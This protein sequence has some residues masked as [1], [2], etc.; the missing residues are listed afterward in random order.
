M[1]ALS[2]RCRGLFLVLATLVAGVS[3]ED[4]LSHNLSVG[5]GNDLAWLKAEGLSSG[6]GGNNS[7]EGSD[8]YNYFSLK[9][10]TPV[11]SLTNWGGVC[12]ERGWI[13]ENG[14]FFG[15]DVGGGGGSVNTDL[16]V[17]GSANADILGIASDTS[18]SVVEVGGGL[19]LG[20]ALS[21]SVDDLR[22]IPGAWIGYWYSGYS[23][24]IYNDA[25]VYADANVSVHDF[26]GPFVKV[27]WRFIE[28]MYRWLIGYYEVN[29]H[30]SVYT[31]GDRWNAGSQIDIDNSVSGFDRNHHQLTVGL[32]FGG[33][34]D[35]GGYS[36]NRR[37]GTMALNIVLPGLGSMVLQKDYLWG[38]IALGVGL[39]GQMMW[40]SKSEMDAEKE[41]DEFGNYHYSGLFP[42]KTTLGKIGLCTVGAGYL[43]GIVRPWIRS[44]PDSG[45]AS[46]KAP[47]FNFAVLPKEG[48]LQYVG[49]YSKSF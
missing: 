35:Y 23:T 3:A 41:V 18:I 1:N 37:L 14:V 21:L 4:V 13:L 31:P 34:G 44:N 45:M 10:K 47:G 8:T 6:R 22:I 43:I 2:Q 19:S 29:S 38:G 25:G 7:G 46:G 27:Q 15:I 12:L 28:I 20:Y 17:G 5:G 24:T 33:E 9:Y 48:D 42:P 39:V 32:Y 30:A 26:F 36:S 40:S 49:S 16:L 11:G